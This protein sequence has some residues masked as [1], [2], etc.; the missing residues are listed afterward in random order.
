[1]KLIARNAKVI[2]ATNKNNIDNELIM[3]KI[4]FVPTWPRMLMIN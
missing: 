3:L 1:M 2:I 4:F